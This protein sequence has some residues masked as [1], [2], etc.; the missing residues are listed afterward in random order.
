MVLA[1]RRWAVLAAV[2]AAAIA[3]ADALG[4]PSSALVAALVVGIGFA[5]S[6]HSPGALPRWAMTAAQAV[7]GVVIG[8]LVQ[9]SSLSALGH[10]W[11]PV[12]GVSILT[13]TLSV[14]GGL[15]LGLHRDVDPLTGSLALTAGGA[16]GL[17]RSA[18]SW[19]PTSAWWPWCSTCGWYWSS[20]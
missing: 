7:L 20:R 6:G 4:V 12:L 5:L 1:L 17:P 8:A 18:A 10:V 13:L 15:L 19:A 11:L 16:S 3:I 14:I 2:T 9:R